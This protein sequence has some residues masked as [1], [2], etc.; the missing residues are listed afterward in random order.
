MANNISKVWELMGYN[1]STG[2]GTYKNRMG[3]GNAI[4][5]DNGIPLDLSSLHASYNDAVVYAATSA[6]AYVDQ[7]IA[8]EGVVYV[9]TAESQGKVK[10]ANYRDSITGKLVTGEEK[11]YDVY[12]KRV[13]IVPTGDDAS[14]VVNEEGLIKMF[15]F[16]GAEAGTVGVKENGKLVWKTLEEIGAGDGNDNTT[17]TFTAIKNADN[18]VYGLTIQPYF[19]E[20]A[21]GEPIEIALEVYTKKEVDAAIKVLAD[22][23]GVEAEEGVDATGLYKLIAD[24]VA[25]AGQAETDLGNRIGYQKAGNS[26]AS[27]VYAYV[28]GV[29]EALVNGVDAEKIDSL[30]ELIAWVEAHPAIVE[31]LDGRLD[32]VE[33]KLV[34][35]GGE[36][37]PE[38]VLEAIAEAIDAENLGQYAKKAEL[39]DAYSKSEVDAL[40]GVPGTPAE[41]EEGAEGYKPAVAGTGVYQHV[42]SKSEVTDLIADIT[43]G[44]S[45]ADVKAELKEY[46]TTN[47]TRVKTIEDKV[48]DI[49]SGAEVNVIEIV[50]VNGNALTPDADR[51]VNVVVPTELA[52]LG[53]YNELDGRVTKNANDIAAFTG[54]LGTTNGN[55]TKNTEAIAALQTK[56]NTDIAGEIA[57]LKGID[58]QLQITIG[59]H[60]TA[61]TNLGLEDARLAGLINGNTSDI[62]TL[63]GQVNIGDTTVTQY[64]ADQLATIKPYDDTEVRQLIANEASRAD[65]EEKRIVGLVETEAARAD[66]AEKANA[67]AILDEKIA[68]ENAIAVVE[69]AVE[70]EAARAQ[71]AEEANRALIDGLD[72][73]LRAALE[74]DGEGL[75][76]IKELALWIEEHETDVVPGINKNKEDIAAL[77]L[78]VAANETAVGVTLPNAIAQALADAKKYADDQDVVVLAAA[79]KYADDQ[80]AITLATAKKYTDDTMVKADGVSIVNNEGTFSVGAVSTDNLVQGKFTLVLNGGDAEVSAE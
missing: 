15:G 63:K 41:G 60:T 42:Y 79:K 10:I 27:G 4:T 73:T 16:D 32:V 1:Y 37:E 53:G 68:R 9:I 51:A 26:P 75:D 23:I 56:V 18:E 3:L 30:N 28:D 36:E 65:T 67:Q 21:Q 47:D 43:G 54:Q 57:A 13:G 11:E 25:R 64:V 24:E 61:L 66:A 20:V 48:T 71:A 70:T 33:A 55:V 58:E 50:K 6:I 22:K 8:A 76:S 14:I 69:A 39:V 7:V 2:T 74:N 52:G 5:R 80:D 49:E 34:G 38:T 59:E 77:T 72:A 62:N 17:Y 29:V 40:I 31:E 19:N 12:L 45:A 46:K 35:I 44:E 78:R